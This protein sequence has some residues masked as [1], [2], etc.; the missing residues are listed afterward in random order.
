MK[1]ILSYIKKNKKEILPNGFNYIFLYILILLPIPISK[2]Y[3]FWFYFPFFVF[4]FFRAIA[5]TEK[6]D[7]SWK[8]RIIVCVIFPFALLIIFFS[9]HLMI[10]T[11]TEGIKK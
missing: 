5:K 10:Q 2:I 1:E 9:I 4:F 7:L 8:N 3:L 11:L 6:D